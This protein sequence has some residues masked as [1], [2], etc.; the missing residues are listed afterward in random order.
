[1]MGTY[2]DA[3]LPARLKQGSL[4]C[5]VIFLVISA[6]LAI[7]AVLSGSFDVFELKIL[8]TTSVIA[9]ASVC[10][11]CCSVYAQRT[12]VAWP[13]AA[14]AGL[15]W[16]SAA[17][18]VYGAWQEVSGEDYWRVTVILG[19]FAIATAHTLSL[20]GLRL[21]PAHD[22]LKP[23]AAIT[24]FA[25]AA[26]ISTVVW[27]LFWGDWIVT[28][29]W[30]LIIVLTIVVVLETLVIPVLTRLAGDAPPAPI[31]EKLLLTRRDEGLYAD[32]HG[33]LYN[34][35]AVADAGGG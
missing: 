29:V 24:I 5:F 27:S 32:A 10:G 6:L 30:N 26:I 3:A 7:A 17:L 15:A 25:L 2:R 23:V 13:G 33:Q 19:I 18:F 12:G 16:V 34:V 31:P 21:R 9:A 1:M 35:R 14:G 4:Y 20:L 22:W 28:G 8:L 11:L